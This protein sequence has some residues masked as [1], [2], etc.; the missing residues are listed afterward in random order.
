MPHSQSQLLKSLG[1]GFEA[2]LEQARFGNNCHIGCATIAVFHPKTHA[3]AKDGAKLMGAV[4]AFQGKVGTL[5]DLFVL[6]VVFGAH[7]EFA[8]DHLMHIA[9]V[10]QGLQFG[11]SPD[12]G[13]F[14][15]HCVHRERVIER[16]KSVNG[17]QGCAFLY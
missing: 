3:G 11:F 1:I 13:G 15:H 9:V 17:S 5:T 2:E 6:E 16:N 4:E 7:N 12:L 8:A 10:G 14:F